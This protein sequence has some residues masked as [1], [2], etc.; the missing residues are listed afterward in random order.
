MPVYQSMQRV[1]FSSPDGYEK[2]KTVFADVRNHLKSLPGFL[3]LTWWIHPRDPSWHNEVSFWTSFDAL[4]DWHM[5][6]Y[7]KSAKEWAVRS[8]A[9]MEDI[10]T[11]FELTTTRLLRICP[12][13]G[14]GQ[15]KSYALEQEQKVLAEPCPK[16]GFHFPV[17]PETSDSSAVFKDAPR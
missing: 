12:C 3:H 6:P 13:C 9:I 10:I 7:H 17:M 15:D 1:R 14:Q 2:F 5:N 4:K 11:N 16:C 8:G